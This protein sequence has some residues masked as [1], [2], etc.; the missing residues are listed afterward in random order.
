[1]NA[2]RWVILEAWVRMGLRFRTIPHNALNIR[3][4]EWQ[5]D[6]NR[7][8]YVYEGDGVW[9]L[10]EPY[11]SPHDHSRV[12]LEMHTESMLH[13]MAHYIT[14]SEENRYQLNFGLPPQEYDEREDRA[15]LAEDS[16]RAILGAASHIAGLA[17]V[18]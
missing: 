6:E 4:E 1:M 7:L 17:L 15:Q 2:D 14:A 18:K 16:I 8:Q 10:R 13:E 11:R 9:L 3:K 5:E 12:S